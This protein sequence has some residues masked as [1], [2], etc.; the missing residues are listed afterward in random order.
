MKFILALIFIAS[1]AFYI[2][3]KLKS[4]NPVITMYVTWITTLI[5]I[6]ILVTTF[7]Y[8]FTHSV[9]NSDGNKGVRGNVGRRGEEGESD[10]CKFK[11]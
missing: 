7:I 1:V 10:F 9:K 11:C 3:G 2:T 8:M 4:D 6:N 5:T